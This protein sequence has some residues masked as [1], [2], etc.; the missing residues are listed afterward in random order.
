MIDLRGVRLVALNSSAD[1]RGRLTA[2]EGVTDVPFEIARVFYVHDVEPGHERG[3]HAHPYT[4]QLLIG[5]GGGLSV[6]V[7]SPSE[8]ITYCLDDP[9]RGLY[10]PEML[11]VRLYAFSPGGVCL[12]IAST[13][14]ANGDVIRDWN[15]YLRAAAG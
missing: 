2:I 15:E 7:C 4:E 11:W 13:H 12:A 10:V 9:T 1:P 8:R 3:G 5:L 6:D 14:Y